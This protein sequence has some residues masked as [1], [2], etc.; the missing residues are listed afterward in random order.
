MTFA[1][2]EELKTCPNSD[3]ALSVRNTEVKTK[4]MP[5][6]ELMKSGKRH[7]KEDTESIDWVQCTELLMLVLF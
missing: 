7:L 5:K 4:I 1:A 2:G 3:I 6:L